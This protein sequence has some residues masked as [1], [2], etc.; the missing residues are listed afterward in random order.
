LSKLRGTY[1]LLCLEDGGYP[2]ALEAR[3]VYRAIADVDAESHG[4]VRVVD[5]S[6]EDFLFPTALFVS[7]TET[8]I[9]LGGPHS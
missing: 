3:K 4:L 2:V 6:D 5:E 7:I 1:F 8:T 9:D